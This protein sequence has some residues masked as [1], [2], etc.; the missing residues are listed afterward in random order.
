MMFATFVACVAMTADVVTIDTKPVQTVLNYKS[1]FTLSPGSKSLP[2]YF[3]VKIPTNSPLAIPVKVRF[4]S[5][6]RNKNKL[7]PKLEQM[8]LVVHSSHSSVYDSYNL[9]RIEDSPFGFQCSVK[10]GAA[11][12]SLEREGGAY[13]NKGT[14]EATVIRM[15]MK[16]ARTAF[17]GDAHSY[18]ESYTLFQKGDYPFSASMSRT[19]GPVPVPIPTW[20][21]VKLDGKEIY[22]VRAGTHK[23]VLR[24]SENLEKGA[25]IEIKLY[26]QETYAD[27]KPK[28]SLVGFPT[29]APPKFGS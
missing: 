4:K 12:F 20:I 19:V 29:L 24:L 23:A 10:G 22:H 6:V 1:E 28:V 17:S 18:S 16:V 26:T 7:A 9:Q 13:D 11:D 5:Y 25:K 27:Q 21:T 15:P 2:N 14:I 8:L 3:H